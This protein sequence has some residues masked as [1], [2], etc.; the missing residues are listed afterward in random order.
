MNFNRWLE[1]ARAMYE[2]DYEL[3]C[4][5]FSFLIYKGRILSI[6]RNSKK[7]NPNNFKVQIGDFFRGTCSE[8]NAI[9][10]IKNKTNLPLSEMTMVNIRLN[11]FLQIRNSRPCSSCQKL[12]LTTGVKKVYHTNDNNGFEQYI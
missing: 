12:L 1:I 2:F 4:Q 10:K 7:T 3:R 11:S 8:F 9:N 5:H 6:G